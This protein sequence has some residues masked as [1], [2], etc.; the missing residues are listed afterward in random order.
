MH[1]Q[2]IGI[3]DL[4]GFLALCCGLHSLQRAVFQVIFFLAFGIA[5]LW[6]YV[7]HPLALIDPCE[8]LLD[9]L[10]RIFLSSTPD[11]HDLVSLQRKLGSISGPKSGH[12]RFFIIVVFCQFLA[13][14][15]PSA[16][17]SAWNGGEGCSSMSW[18]GTGVTF[19]ADVLDSM[20]QTKLHDKTPKVDL[21]LEKHHFPFSCATPVQKRSYKRAYHRSCKFGYAW[22]RGRLL[23]PS[24]FPVASVATPPKPV[25]TS[26]SK[27]VHHSAVGAPRNRLK[28]MHVN[29]G[30]L[31]RAR[32]HEIQYWAS[33]LDL[34]LILLS[35]TR[36]SFGSEWSSADWHC[37]HSGSSD[38]SD[39]LL[40]MVNA[41]K[42]SSDRLLFAE[43]I[44]GRLCHL[45]I[46]QHT[47]AID[48][49]GCYQFTDT[50]TV[51]CRTSRQ[52]FW[53]VL[54]RCCDNLPRRNTMLIA[55]D[56][57]CSLPGDGIRVGTDQYMYNG[58]H[59]KGPQHSDQ[60][61]FYSILLQHQLI[62]LNSWNAKDPPSY[63]NGF[64]SSRIDYFLMRH[65]DC[66]SLSK[67]VSCLPEASFLPVSGAYHTPMICT[68]RKFPCVFHKT[69]SLPSCNYQQRLSCRYT[70]KECPMEWQQF[71]N[72]FA[73]AL[74]TFA[75]DAEV[76]NHVITDL[77]NHLMPCFQQFFPKQSK[78]G[79]AP[80]AIAQS[81]VRA[82]W[83]HRQA[84]YDHKGSSLANIFGFW[85]HH[86]QFHKLQK[87]QHRQSRI[88]Q[89]QKLNDLLHDIN[90]SFFKHD[91]F[92]IFQAVNK[93]TPKQVKRP[94][95]LR[96]L[97][98]S[99][100]DPADEIR[101]LTTYVQ[102]VWDGPA[103]LPFQDRYVP[104][105]PFDLEELRLEIAAIPAIKAVARP[106]IPG[107]CL[108]QHAH[109]LAD[110]VYTCLTVW[111]NSTP[112]YIPTE[113]KRGWLTFINKPNKTPDRPQNLRPL[114]MQEPLSKCIL[115]ILTRKL[116]QQLLRHITRWPQFAFLQYRSSNDAIR[117]VIHHVNQVRCLILNHRRSVQQRAAGATCHSVCGGLQMYLDVHQAFDRIPRDK[118]F[119]FLWTLDIDPRILTLMTA[120]HEGT[121]YALWI[122]QAFHEVHTGRGVRQGCRAAPTLWNVFTLAIFHYLAGQISEEWVKSCLTLF[123]DDLHVGE[124]F[125]S[126]QQLSDALERLGL[127]LDG[128]EYHGLTISLDK[129]YVIL[130]ITGTNC[131]QTKKSI[132]QRD[133]DGEF[134]WIPRAHGPA[135]KLRVRSTAKY[136]G[137]TIGYL[138][139]ETLTLQT[140]IK[141]AQHNFCRLKQWL[142][143]H[144]LALRLRLQIWYSCVY[145]SLT[146]GIFA[147]NLSIQNILHLQQVIMRMYRQ[148]LGDH[149]FLTHRSHKL[150]LQVNQ[151]T[152]P[153]DLLTQSASGLQCT[154]SQ[155]L[156]HLHPQDIVCGIDWTNV[157]ALID[158]IQTVKDHSAQVDLATA[159]L[160]SSEVTP[161]VFRCDFC[162][163]CS[164]SL[165][166]LRRH[167][168]TVHNHRTLRTPLGNIASHA[169]RGLPQCSHCFESFVSWRNFRTH[170]ERNVCQVMA[171]R[172]PEVQ[173]EHFQEPRRCAMQDR[174]LTL[175]LSK[176]YGTAL[177]HLIPRRL[178][179]EL[180][181]QPNALKDLTSHCILC[182]Q[183][184]GRPQELNG[185]LR[186][187]H[188]TW[189][190]HVLNKSAQLGRSQA[191]HSPCRFCQKQFV[192]VHSCPVLT[193]CALLLVNLESNGGQPGLVHPE[194][195]HCEICCT[196]FDTV[197]ALHQHL[198]TVHKLATQD[199]LPLRDQLGADPVCRHC[200]SLFSHS[201][202]LRQ[203]ISMGQCAQFNPEMPL[204]ITPVKDHW[205]QILLSGDVKSLQK[206]PSHRVQLTVN[207]QLC[208][209][210]YQ[211]A[212]DLMLHLQTTHAEEWQQSQKFCPLLLKACFQPLGC[213]CN[214]KV[215]SRGLQHSCPALRQLSLMAVRLNQD[216][217]IPWTFPTP[218][219]DVYMST[220]MTPALKEH[221]HRS[222]DGRDFVGLW[223]DVATMN[224]LST[225][226]LGCGGHF[227][228]FS[229]RDHRC[230]EGC[231][232][233][234]LV[235]DLM[236]Q[237][238]PVIAK[239]FTVD[240]QCPACHMTFNTVATDTPDPA[241]QT[242]RTKL[243][244]L[245]LL[246]HCPALLQLSDLLQHGIG[247]S[248]DDQ[249]GGY[250][251]DGGLWTDG[252][253]VGGVPKRSQRRKRP[254][255]T[256]ERGPQRTKA[257][258]SG[259]APTGYGTPLASPRPG[260][261]TDEKARLLGLL[262]AN[263]SYGSPASADASGDPVEETPG[264]VE[265]GQG[266]HDEPPAP[267][268]SADAHSSPL[269]LR[270]AGQTGQE[271]GIRPTEDHG[272]E[273]R[274]DQCSG[275]F[276]V[277]ALEPAS[278]ADAKHQPDP[279]ATC[280]HDQVCRAVDRSDQ[281]FPEHHPLPG[282]ETTGLGDSLP[283][284]ASGQ[285]AARRPSVP[286]PDPSR[287][288]SVAHHWHADEASQ[289]AAQS[290]CD[291]VEGPDEGQRP[292]KGIRQGLQGSFE[293]LIAPDSLRSRFE[294]LQLMNLGNHCYIN[295]AF[296]STTWAMLSVKGFQY[297]QWGAC[298][299]DV[300]RFIDSAG[301]VT[302]SLIDQPFFQELIETWPDVHNQGDPVE[303][304]AHMLRGL[305]FEGMNMSWD[306]RVQIGHLVHLHD[307]NRDPK[308]PLVLYLDPSLMS[309]HVIM[310]NQLILAWSNQNGMQ[311]A[312]TG[313]SPLVCIQI[314]RNVTAGDGTVTTSDLRIEHHGG[315]ELP[316]FIG[317]DLQ[318]IWKE[319]QVTSLV[320]HTGMDQAGHCRTL[321][322]VEPTSQTVPKPV[323]SLLTDDND[324]PQRNWKAPN[325][326]NRHV[327]CFWLCESS[328][329]DLYKVPSMP[330][331][332]AVPGHDPGSFLR[333]MNDLNAF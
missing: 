151:L 163:F 145:M 124:V 231:K 132:L 7:N 133:Q 267:E 99:P 319:F 181:Q 233:G 187:K 106:F 193:Q 220:S 311:Y 67:Q 125:Y 2:S 137:V 164:H 136:L 126:A 243:A 266:H 37:L 90:Q 250:R 27:P 20:Y 211:R 284:D 157:Q 36:W 9:F 33:S 152:H 273:T 218:G 279:G 214:P 40:F 108:K 147:V 15:H 73:A 286:L 79:A 206:M 302:V 8:Y 3:S 176:T 103:C 128:L 292:G 70:W 290:T 252:Q 308:A 216:L 242:T 21:G 43:H 85:Y 317:D 69:A 174:H 199:W 287:L 109:Q 274:P 41:K 258:T 222:L 48:F 64:S 183:Y 210:S 39:G 245:H 209:M 144:R 4:L 53:T 236:H 102:E 105:V 56:F 61:Q 188:P 116:N 329:T 251:N 328:Q 278:E 249:S 34:D 50:R 138:S 230:Q 321:L 32:L 120:W 333:E 139:S 280:P 62:A 260:T 320:T 312:L 307:C 166:N 198:S 213:F 168:T 114:C 170:I 177:L 261:T 143:T 331:A 80:D 28:T 47:R 259:S 239:T 227:H 153:L 76:H 315:C 294:Q 306:A 44:P 98:G 241:V 95:R 271:P 88:Y 234:S 226:C 54:S 186:T 223:L 169:V 244:Q 149:S 83:T 60:Q 332:T 295:S 330:M 78:R 184:H 277:S 24:N 237:L 51:T 212:G 165:A 86:S 6:N 254:E 154:L 171:M 113:W 275:P 91:S 71:N 122:N 191:S 190:P 217:F 283:L 110:L 22:Y 303:F 68:V 175:L 324:A 291:G 215:S 325:W 131:R 326:I 313:T 16:M 208:E 65:A 111:W 263:R 130:Y 201:S 25:P 45:R 301:P 285:F 270:E 96:N 35:E 202:A 141:A 207:C 29:V 121:S 38:R 160:Q 107:I 89:K 205:Q 180:L 66:D 224:H 14:F 289:S 77:H 63:R 247:P 288:H 92:T 232:P 194:V 74:D 167:C 156:N 304:I 101:L 318:V 30:G 262:S 150:F 196:R 10:N 140:R 104:G 46:R 55:G 112:P 134:V 228:P 327:T 58:V 225:T 240:H 310:L 1:H 255:E 204:Q 26:S 195:L 185:H 316:F 257:R 172:Q 11:W 81:L 293:G 269:S 52:K 42:F 299:R 159:L 314:E 148:I 49:V 84:M 18:A 179:T 100:A 229:L 281:R 119:D 192:N 309:E 31:S 87:Q 97:D 118:L 200:F 57:N 297:E 129:S 5:T 158:L 12:S 94:I 17:H 155:R 127:L 246:Y 235:T 13:V 221:V 298:A 305:A 253:H 161:R 146:Y 178:W 268:M 142:C 323:L 276:P 203:H 93:H 72:S 282:H 256:Q 75:T 300:I 296:L 23:H 123:A 265:G 115:G 19:T 197:G 117:R 82:K 272:S 59:C 173:S 189:M 135:S 182:G 219:S 162:T 264:G 322:Q 248:C 238:V